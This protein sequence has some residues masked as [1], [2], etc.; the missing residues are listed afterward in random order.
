MQADVA[1]AMLPFHQVVSSPGRKSNEEPSF[2]MALHCSVRLHNQKSMLIQTGS[3]DSSEYSLSH[4]I[5][6][7]N[8]A[9]AVLES[10]VAPC[11]SENT[12]L[13]K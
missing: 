6:S 1:P 7:N 11:K 13:R 3:Q 10:D 5:D 2:A 8:E 12:R 9:L 4:T